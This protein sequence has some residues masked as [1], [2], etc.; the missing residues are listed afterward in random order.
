MLD[1]IA[2]P[3]ASVPTPVVD[4]AARSVAIQG[5]SA[6]EQFLRERGVEWSEALTQAR[7]PASR[8]AGGIVPYSDR[9]VQTL[10]RRFRDLDD[11]SRTSLVE[12]LAKTLTSFS[13]GNL[14]GHE[15]FFAWSG[16]NIQTADVQGM[17]DLV[18]YSKSWSEVTSAWKELDPRFPGNSSA[19]SI[20]HRLA[21]L[22]H[23]AAHQ[24]DAV[25]DPIAVSTTT[26]NVK[27][28]AMLVDIA[29]SHALHLM[30]LGEVVKP[31][32]G[33]QLR[34][35]RILR[36]GTRWPEYGPSAKRAHRRHS[37]M[38]E[39]VREA[40]ARAKAHS[41]ILLALNGNEIVDWRSTL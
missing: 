41:E 4:N 36:D 19:E 22:R 30:C 2:S 23:T 16:S 18:G 34:V 40:S 14:V 20:V 3:P 28:A 9:I 32:L 39:A 13:Y 37:S 5:L 35:R 11:S 21:R 10:P 29:I 38:D 27:L 6:F 33:A 25:L 26:R 15:L 1:F 31:G 24:V 7:I 17:L 8:L 12:D